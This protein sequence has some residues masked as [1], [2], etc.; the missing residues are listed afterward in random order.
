MDHAPREGLKNTI[1]IDSAFKNEHNSIE[2]QELGNVT[3]L[4]D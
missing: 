3:E 1:W 4:V 2:I